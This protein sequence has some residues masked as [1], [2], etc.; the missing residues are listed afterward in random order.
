MDAVLHSEVFFFISSVGFILLSIIVFV[1]LFYI[2][3]AVRSFTSLMEK[4]GENVDS[5]GYAGR[6]LI[7]DMRNSIAF[8]LLFRNKKK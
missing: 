2:T 3:R 1:L 8:R 4:I 6:E 5:V 7:E